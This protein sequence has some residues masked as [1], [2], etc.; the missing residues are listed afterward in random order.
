MLSIYLLELRVGGRHVSVFGGKIGRPNQ[1]LI[2]PSHLGLYYI[3]AQVC[4]S[5]QAQV[6]F[7]S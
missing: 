1:I 6:I 4:L 7:L 3:V 5:Y 2:V